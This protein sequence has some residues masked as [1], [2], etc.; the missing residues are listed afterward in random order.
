MNVENTGHSVRMFKRI[1]FLATLSALTLT[2]HV[3]E[4]GQPYS[5]SLMDCAALMD[6]SNRMNS[7]RAN[8]GNGLVLSRIAEALEKAAYNQ[9]LDEGRDNPGAYLEQLKSDKVTH[10]DAKGVSFVFSDEFKDWMAYCRKFSAHLGID[11]ND[12]R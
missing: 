2:P 3:A 6:M 10:W 12:F 1:S 8:H 7:E 11:F 4:A 9:S 5:E